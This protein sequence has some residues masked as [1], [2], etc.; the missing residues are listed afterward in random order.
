[1]LNVMQKYKIAILKNEDPFDHEPWIKACERHPN[2]I[3]YQVIEIINQDWLAQVRSLSPQL[4]LLKPS[5]RTELYRALYQERVD[6]IVNDLGIEVFP[7]FDELRIYE[8]KKFF[9]YWA[10]ANAIPHPQTWVFYSR[11]EADEY[12]VNAVLPLVAK[13]NIGASGKG[14][15]IIR[16]TAELLSYIHS[17]FN[18]GI[19]SQTGP[20]LEKGKLLS[21]LLQKLTHPRELA[22]R[23]HAYKTVAADRQKGYLIL[24]EFVPHDF[25]W[26]VVRIG[27]S[28]F[29]HKKLKTG[30]KASGTLLKDYGNPPLKLL[31]F[32]YDHTGRF[33]FHSVAV[34]LFECGNS[35]LVNEIQCIFGQS[36]AYQMLVD[37]RIG[38]YTRIN[39][40]WVFEEGDFAANACYNLRLD[41]ALS[42]L[43]KA[44]KIPD[45]KLN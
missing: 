23:L 21:R 37:G 30:D 26:R 9:A 3:S 6:I 18:E 41:W 27:D 16:T 1:M 19:V 31:D 44:D 32:V 12:A 4:C 35:Y 36:D 33:S 28:L 11:K 17:A 2:R 25:E 14:V 5:G 7:S 20:R 39:E 8:N 15:K 13:K 10:Q 34:D 45:V 40:A 43:D 29:A 24:Q 38:R 22:N 42:Q